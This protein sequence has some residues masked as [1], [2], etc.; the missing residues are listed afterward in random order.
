MNQENLLIKVITKVIDKSPASAYKLINAL[1]ELGIVKEITGS[2]RGRL[3]MFDN[4]LN[5]F[6]DKDVKK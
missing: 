3:Y 2:E 5:L 4:Y 6:T 1:E